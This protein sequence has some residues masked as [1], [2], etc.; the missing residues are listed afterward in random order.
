MQFPGRVVHALGVWGGSVV[1]VGA[2]GLHL[3]VQN[4]W[5]EVDLG[6]EPVALFSAAASDSALALGGRPGSGFWIWRSGAA[7]PESVAIPM[8]RANCMAWGDGGDLWL[9]GDRGVVRWQGGTA[10]TFA[11]NDARRDQVTALLEHEGKLYV[12][13][14]AGL[15]IAAVRNLR[16]AAAVE[17]ESQGERL[18]LLQG[19]PDNN[20]TGLLAHDSRVW[21]ATQGGLARLE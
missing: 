10:T 8:G 20:V 6:H 11:W 13:S 14:E 5:N 3:F 15:W 16:R 18:G 1:A 12:G 19:L 2:A 21:V 7:R 9:G 4:E 17:L